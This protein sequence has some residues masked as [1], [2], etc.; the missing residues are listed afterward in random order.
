VLA[1]E[2]SSYIAVGEGVWFYFP[3][4]GGYFYFNRMV[5]VGEVWL[6]GN[7]SWFFSLWYGNSFF[8]E[9]MV[10]VNSSWVWVKTFFENKVFE[11]WAWTNM[12]DPIFYFTSPYGSEPYA[13]YRMDSNTKLRKVVTP[14]DV[15][16]EPDTWCYHNNI[17][18]IHV[19]Q[20]GDHDILVRVLFKPQ[21][22]AKPLTVKPVHPLERLIRD[23]H[24]F[25]RKLVESLVKWLRSLLG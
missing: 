20:T 1:E 8:S 2:S 19:K 14:T 13:V 6:Y 11:A 21:P 7:M 15:A 16:R 4:T 12:S 5:V 24:S 25:L 9:W 10:G 3:D 22:R 17:V 23:A 18:Y